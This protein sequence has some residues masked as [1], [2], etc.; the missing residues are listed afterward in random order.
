MIKIEHTTPEIYCRQSRDFQFIGRL[1]ELVAN[2]LQTNAEPIDR[3]WDTDSRDQRFNGLMASTLGFSARKTYGDGQLK[4]L[5]SV[6][7]E[8]LRNKGSLSSIRT[9]LTAMMRA[10]GIT[11][12][13]GA[14]AS[15]DGL[16]IRLF[17]PPELPDISLLNE[18]LD[19]LLPAGMSCKISRVQERNQTIDPT[20][21]GAAEEILASKDERSTYD[22]L[23]NDDK[24]ANDYAEDTPDYVSDNGIYRKP[25]LYSNAQLWQKDLKGGNDNG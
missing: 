13:V 5:C 4:A 25:G 17:V 21:I 7:S 2:Y 10:E 8:A 22:M 24:D 16:Q 3:L 15:E 9:V 20:D 23:W 12:E 11:S 19:Y 6:F 18:A 1:F 14:Q